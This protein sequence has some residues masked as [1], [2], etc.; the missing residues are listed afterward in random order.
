[1]LSELQRDPTLTGLRLPSRSRL[2]VLFKTACP[3][4]VAPRRPRSPPQ[5]APGAPTAVHE[6][7]Q[8]DCQEAL[9]LADDHRASI[10]TLRD[11]SVPPS[12]SLRPLT[13]R[14]AAV[15]AA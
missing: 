11:L 2:A 7:W 15:A 8:L 10:C 1:V 3:E 13:S 4:L 6:C 14:A 5:P 9:P 12:S